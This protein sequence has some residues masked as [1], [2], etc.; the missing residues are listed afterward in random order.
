MQRQSRRPP[1]RA[2]RPTARSHTLIFEPPGPAIGRGVDDVHTER[3]HARR[4]LE[5]IAIV[6][7]RHLRR[8]AR[9]IP[10]SE[11]DARP[12]AF[13]RSDRAS[14][15]KR[16]S[17]ALTEADDERTPGG[18]WRRRASLGR[19]PRATPP[20]RPRVTPRRRRRTPPRTRRTPRSPPPRRRPRASS[21]PPPSAPCTS[22]PRLRPRPRR[23]TSTPPLLPRL[24][25]L[26]RTRPPPS[27]PPRRRPRVR[28]PPHPRPPRPAPTPSPSQTPS[29]A[30]SVDDRTPPGN[31]WTKTSPRRTTATPPRTAPSP[32]TAATPSTRTPTRT[33]TLTTTTTRWTRRLRLRHPP[34]LR[35][36]PR[37]R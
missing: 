29:C 4:P 16:H 17:S 11:A 27:P 20:R 25:R 26:P 28:C 22:L 36:P 31:S 3:D 32:S 15:E 14:H 1:L 23:T 6:A 24:P 18:A 10:A 2:R 35:S 21:S 33:R 7:D 19:S 9:S 37:S 34:V 12:I 8:I 13:G 30:S 5:R